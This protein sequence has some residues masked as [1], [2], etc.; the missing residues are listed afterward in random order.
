L[1]CWG[2]IR[3]LI[4][5]S[6]PSTLVT[7]GHVGTL[8]TTSSLSCNLA[9]SHRVSNLTISLSVRPFAICHSSVH[10]LSV[11]LIQVPWG[12]CNFFYFIWEGNTIAT[13][14][15]KRF[16]KHPA[17]LKPS[18]GDLCTFSIKAIVTFGTCYISC[19]ITAASDANMPLIVDWVGH[20]FPNITS[21]A[22]RT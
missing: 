15:S 4:T 14:P 17:A 11:L 5:R 21:F 3:N 12:F 19:A 6:F 16:S 8:V 7:I 20:H 10:W 1:N 9:T 13:K 18:I 22:S 2:I